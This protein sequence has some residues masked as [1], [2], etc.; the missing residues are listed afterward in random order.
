[1]KGSARME[2]CWSCSLKKFK[3]ILLI[4]EMNKYY[5]YSSHFHDFGYFFF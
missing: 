4:K 2:E 3:E 1:M 5:A